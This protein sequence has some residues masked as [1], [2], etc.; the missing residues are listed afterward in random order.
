MLIIMM[1]A[2][3]FTVVKVKG[4][5]KENTFIERPVVQDRKKKKIIKDQ[6]YQKMKDNKE[7]ETFEIDGTYE[8]VF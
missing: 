6:T 4:A 5:A 1:W 8:K 3:V 7:D 2:S